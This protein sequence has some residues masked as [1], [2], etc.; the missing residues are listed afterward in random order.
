MGK[1]KTPNRRTLEKVG[2]D[3][4]AGRYEMTEKGKE[5]GL[6]LDSIADQILS[7]LPMRGQKMTPEELV[8]MGYF[9]GVRANSTEV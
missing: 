6:A 5:L 8:V 2:R 4:D 7:Q 3:W 9:F 1:Q